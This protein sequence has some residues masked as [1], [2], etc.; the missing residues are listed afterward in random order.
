MSLKKKNSMLR[1]ICTAIDHSRRQNVVSISRAN[2]AAP[3]LPL[4]CSCRHFNVICDPWLNRRMA[5]WNLFVKFK[6]LRRK[7]R[8]CKCR[9]LSWFVFCR[10][11]PWICNP[12]ATLPLIRGTCLRVSQAIFL[13]QTASRKWFSRWYGTYTKRVSAVV[14]HYG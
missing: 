11:N 5:T 7:S 4:F 14:W 13:A 3:R 6:G 1:C 10:Q 8:R 9:V 12:N 2:S